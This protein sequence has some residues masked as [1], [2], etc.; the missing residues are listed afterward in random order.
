M[1]GRKKTSLT[2]TAPP[3]P[4][5]RAMKQGVR[6][7]MISRN[8]AVAW[9][10]AASA[11]SVSG[12]ALASGLEIPEGGALGLARGGAVVARPTDA[13]AVAYNPAGMLGL[14]GAQLTLGS[15]FGS[16]TQ[17][18][19]R[20]GNYATEDDT[21]ITTANTPFAMSSYAASGSVTPFPRTCNNPSLALAPN[22]AFTYRI[23]PNFA[24]GVSAVPPHTVGREGIYPDSVQ[25]INGLAPSPARHLLFEKR[26]LL[27]YPSVSVAFAPVPWLR[28]G[29]TLQ[30]GLASFEYATML[31]PQDGSFSEQS[32][33]ADVKLTLRAGGTFIAGAAGIQVLFPRFFTFGIK[34]QYVP[35]LSLS[36]DNGEAVDQYYQTNMQR[37]ST[38]RIDALRAQPPS[39]I[40]AGLRFA[41]PRAG[42]PNAWESA[43]RLAR[44]NTL[45]NGRNI[46]DTYD[47]MRDDVFDVEVNF[48]YEFTSTLSETEVALSG[49]ITAGGIAVNLNPMNPIKIRSDFRNTFGVR[50]GSDWNVIP[51]RL[52]LRMGFS[53]ETGASTPGLS[54]LHLPTYD[55]FSAHIGA[56]L[57]FGWFTA[58]LSYAHMFFVPLEDPG[59]RREIITTA[60]LRG[61]T[62]CMANSTNTRAGSC[63]VNAARYE[64]SMDLVGLNLS[65]RW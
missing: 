25:T 45:A 43:H 48:N 12:E 7:M 27:F 30:V 13:L 20:Y 55:S 23:L 46:E 19:Q 21:G 3:L 62:L 28:L 53:A 17:C 24:V 54:Q 65:A 44:A 40:R 36:G 41:M 60:A 38:F 34:G 9:V 26:L 33:D 64:G 59:G 32:P 22:L 10:L 2:K 61:Q 47:P 6:G 50:I 29:A 1:R 31:N 39:H 58:Q 35:P 11:A 4:H 56:A 49:Q 5:S 15:N 18:F 37:R 63:S 14:A 8:K 52:A 42:R 57:R 51:D 16:F